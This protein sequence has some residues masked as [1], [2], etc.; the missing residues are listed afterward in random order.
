M[1]KYSK[2]SLPEANP[3]PITRPINTA[4]ILMTSF[5]II[6]SFRKIV[7]DN[8]LFLQYIVDI[9]ENILLAQKNYKKPLTR[10]ENYDNIYLPLKRGF[11]CVVKKRKSYMVK[12]SADDKSSDGLYRKGEKDESKNHIGLHRM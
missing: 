9:V 11:I 3:A 4:E 7:E 2:I 12:N 1:L 10:L 6:L 8:I 5:I